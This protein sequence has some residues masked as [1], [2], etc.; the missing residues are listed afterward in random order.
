MADEKLLDISKHGGLS[1]G[2]V[3]AL[4]LVL[5]VWVGTLASGSSRLSAQEQL[6]TEA[7]AER[8][9]LQAKVTALELRVQRGEDKTDSILAALS[10][11]EATMKERT[12]YA[13]G[14]AE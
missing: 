9:A 3:A 5:V 13:K 1:L 2:T 4:V 8:A 12:I 6:T 10:K 14:R 11:L 7:K